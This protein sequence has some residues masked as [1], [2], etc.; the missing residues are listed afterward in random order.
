[1]SPNTRVRPICRTLAAS[2]T[3][4]SSRPCSSSD[5]CR[6]LERCGGPASAAESACRDV[7]PTISAGWFRLPFTMMPP[8]EGN[9]PPLEE[10]SERAKTTK[11]P[12]EGP[13]FTRHT[14]QERQERQQRH[15]QRADCERSDNQD[16]GAPADDGERRFV[17]LPY[18]LKGGALPGG[19]LAPVD[20]GFASAV[21]SRPNAQGC[22][23]RLTRCLERPALIA[24]SVDR[25]RA[26]RDFNHELLFKSTT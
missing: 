18:V 14:R 10:G 17:T 20:R 6:C 8:F 23:G 12:F 5:R 22:A 4:S 24:Q 11:I 21:I 1:M 7:G 25:T 9:A 16:E 26:P 3:V 2:S 19:P 13:G 15:V